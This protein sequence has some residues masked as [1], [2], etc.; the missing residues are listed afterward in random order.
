MTVFDTLKTMNGVG[1]RIRLRHVRD[2]LPMMSRKA[3]DAELMRLQRE[4]MIMIYPL[5]NPLDITL[6]DKAAALVIAGEPHHIIYR[7]K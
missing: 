1:D 3:L 6:A 5:D 2:W 7:E 4:R